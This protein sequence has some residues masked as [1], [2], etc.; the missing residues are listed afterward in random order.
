[1]KISPQSPTVPSLLPDPPQR[2]L[3][4]ASKPNPFSLT[5]MLVAQLTVII[6]AV[7]LHMDSAH[8]VTKFKTIIVLTMR[9]LASA[10]ACCFQQRVVRNP[11]CFIQ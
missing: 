10:P 9:G 4:Q 1:M 7:S 8:S 6:G 3:I 2:I 5:D 11:W